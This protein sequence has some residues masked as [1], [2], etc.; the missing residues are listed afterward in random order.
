MTPGLCSF[1]RRAVSRF[2]VDGGGV[3]EVECRAFDRP[4]PGCPES[5]SGKSDLL[6]ENS[7][8]GFSPL[9]R[10]HAGLQ[11]VQLQESTGVSAESSQNSRQTP[12]WQV[13]EE[14]V[15]SNTT[16][17]YVWSPV[18]VDAL[19][20]R[21]RDTDGNGTLDERLW[22]QQDANW[23][24]TA[25]VDG[26]GAVV[27]RYAYDPFGSVTVYD[28]SYGVR[29]GGSLYSATYLWQ[30]RPMDSISG[31]Y[32][33]RIRDVSWTLG[34]PIQVDMLRFGA[35]DVNFYRWEGNRP[36]NVV[37]PLGLD[38]QTG[39]T[40]TTP[41]GK[42]ESIKENEGKLVGKITDANGVVVL[43]VWVINGALSG[44]LPN[45]NKPL[46]FGICLPPSGHNVFF[47]NT[48]KNGKVTDIVWYNIGPNENKPKKECVAFLE[49]PGKGVSF[50]QER[51][52]E[53]AKEGYLNPLPEKRRPCDVYMGF[54]ALE[55]VR[56]TMTMTA[57]G[58]ELKV[59]RL[60][61]DNKTGTIEWK[62]DSKASV[63]L[64]PSE[65][66]K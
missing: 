12:R 48:D 59:H 63:G 54:T 45:N 17:R 51:L 5:A 27:E 4:R 31:T 53:A 20:L 62:E 60:Y 19:V 10:H 42:I 29:G 46:G 3:V 13:L 37:D 44:R 7:H 8:L 38:W 66:P 57:K 26:S 35:G 64:D 36:V 11:P 14:K 15:G 52:P 65:F 43:E 21:D 34:R 58:P 1:A 50:S 28:S 30:G 16:R 6:F 24:V 61:M 49:K 32:N 9:P 56:Y 41:N 39:L 55:T 33:F 2:R 47:Y 40:P 22:A 25:L 23:N 18:Y